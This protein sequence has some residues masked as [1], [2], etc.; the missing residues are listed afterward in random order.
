MCLFLKTHDRLEPVFV[1]EEDS[2]SDPAAILQR[3]RTEKETR[4]EGSPSLQTEDRKATMVREIQNILASQR[5][6][7]A[8]QR[9]KTKADAAASSSSTATNNAAEKKKE[10]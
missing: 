2:S 9:D 4:N 1:P 3:L 7:S 8:A 6:G 10:K 5:A